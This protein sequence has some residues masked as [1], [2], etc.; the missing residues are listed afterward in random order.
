[1]ELVELACMG[2]SFTVLFRIGKPR[3]TK[4]STVANAFF[5]LFLQLCYE[6]LVSM[7]DSNETLLFFGVVVLGLTQ[8]LSG[9]HPVPSARLMFL[10]L[11]KI[12]KDRLSNCH[13]LSDQTSAG[14]SRIGTPVSRSRQP[15]Q[16]GEVPG[17]LS[18]EAHASR[19]RRATS[20]AKGQATS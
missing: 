10:R 14:A 19:R 17:T 20:T 12:Q 15:R 1:M 9:T 13:L 3:V 2:V 11:A 18:C 6:C 5:A 4:N 7:H 16:G 8:H